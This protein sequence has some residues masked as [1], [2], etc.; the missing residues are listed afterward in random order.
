MKI[1]V[2]ITIAISLV[3]PIC[4]VPV[5]GQTV[6]TDSPLSWTDCVTLALSNN[7]DLS[8]SRYALAASKSSYKG[9]YNAV[10]PQVALSNSY[11]SSDNPSS[12]G[13]ANSG[14]WQAQASANLN[15]FNKAAYAS[16][17]GAK[18]QTT[19]QQAN[20]RQVS[21]LLRFNLRKAFAQLL[22]AQKNIEV[23]KNIVA[24]RREE[25][26]M[27]ILR[28]NSGRE[29]KGNMLRANAQ[30]LQAKADLAQSERDL[31]T[32][33]AVLNRQLGLDDFTA[34]AVTGTLNTTQAPPDAPK[35]ERAL[36][37]D[38]PDVALQE[39]AVKSAETGLSQSESSFWP[40]L[41][42]NYSFSGSG[43]N[44]IP[45]LY[46]S[47]GVGLQ[48]PLF[49]GGPT[50]TYYARSAAKNNL[51]K[52]RQD[53]RSVREQAIVDIETSWSTFAGAVDQLRVQ[54]A[55]LEASRQRNDEAN[56]RYDS[57][58]LTYDN[59]EIIVSDRVNQERQAI[60]AQLNSVTAEA[61]WLKALGKP[62]EE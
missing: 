21:S 27:V 62:I 39:A 59:W 19:Q 52:A 47:W 31:R 7:A 57:G 13:G 10:L 48:Y 12:T 25:A 34:I 1:K 8:S 46:S 53:L 14:N 45:S 26:Q 35:D 16:I 2:I 43:P 51:E 18:A 32:A 49:G 6:R 17:Q 22:F 37:K 60:Q 42:A 20:A 23:S 61:A 41:S 30:S 28:Y 55:L 11:S 15:I 24:M 58:L 29:S 36:M 3:M 38:R 44:E 50:A 33:R 56:I 54:S 4:L 5:F 9:S 40:V